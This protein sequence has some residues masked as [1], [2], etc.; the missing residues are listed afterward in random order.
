MFR[1]IRQNFYGIATGSCLEKVGA[2]TTKFVGTDDTTMF[3]LSSEAAFIS[4]LP[5]TA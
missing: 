5:F 4:K 3:V 1:E 2:W